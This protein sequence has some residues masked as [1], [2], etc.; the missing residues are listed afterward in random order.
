MV[1]RAWWCKLEAAVPL[2]AKVDY[3]V[4]NNDDRRPLRFG[5]KVVRRVRVEDVACIGMIRCHH[6]IKVRTSAYY[7]YIYINKTNGGARDVTDEVPP[8]ILEKKPMG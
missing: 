6:Q 1:T 5:D 2:V 3:L 7:I 4:T 8:V